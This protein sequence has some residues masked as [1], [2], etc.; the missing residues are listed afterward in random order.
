MSFLRAASHVRCASILLAL[1]TTACRHDISDAQLIEMS[2][3]AA[4][5]G[6]AVL[7]AGHRGP[8]VATG[9]QGPARFA[10][11]V[12]A[13][14]SAERAFATTA[15]ADRW[16]REP[17]NEGFE[18][19]VDEV[20]KGLREAGFGSADGFEI[21]IVSTPMK[22]PAW[23]PRSAR[24]SLVTGGA[25]E[26]VLHS[27]D[28]PEDRD[29][30]ILPRNAP[31][32]DV[33]GRLV[34]ALDGVESGCVLLV[35][36]PLQSKLLEDAKTRGAVLVL[37]SSLA[38]YNVDPVKGGERHLDA[39]GYRHAPYP[40]VLPVAQVSPRTAGILRAA[41]QKAPAARVRF[42]CQT[43][44]AERPLRTIV[45]TVVGA[46]R[47]D[48]CVAMAAHIQEP[49]ACDNASGVG[50]LLEAAHTAATL[51]SGGELPRP[52]RSLCFVFGNEIEQSRIFLDHTKRSCVAAIAADMTG[53]A[54][55]KTGAIALLERPQDPGALAALPPDHHTAWSGGAVST[56][57]AD[58][59]VPTG[60][61]VIARCALIDIGSLQSAWSTDEH[62]FEGGSDHV[63]YLERKI[64]AV[65]FWHFPDFTYHTSLDRIEN[66]DAEEMHRTGSALLSTAL[67][68]ADPRPTDLDRYLQSLRI[69]ADVRA[70]ACAQ[71]GDD[72]TAAAWGE[73]VR[74]ARMWLRNL[75]LVTGAGAEP[76][77][78]MGTRKPAPK[79]TDTK[80]T[81]KKENP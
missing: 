45:A 23:T 10:P 48:E 37:S 78:P 71:A 76:A 51:I 31:A 47:P 72:T 28:A 79:N 67:A 65:L 9:A 2:K 16:Y 38:D 43:E 12:F 46:S 69:E 21:E 73:W 42:R 20:E 59:I 39:V 54:E 6:P 26:R 30:T 60:I 70:Q 68:L 74:G 41:I 3:A 34:T 22:S 24:L 80:T 36:T 14:F 15:F 35:D 18:A 27:F 63:V 58:E 75:C 32:A 5:A 53:E 13:A 81:G 40:P 25:A 4:H 57:K 50:T 8:P 77:Q 11:Q 52:A 66:V 64:P 17:A 61:A 33:E 7:S 1:A 19:V 56:A 44:F 55:A 49:G 62:P 29:R